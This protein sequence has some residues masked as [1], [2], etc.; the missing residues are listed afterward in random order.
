MDAFPLA[1]EFGLT[2]LYSFGAFVFLLYELI[3]GKLHWS[4]GAYLASVS[5]DCFTFCTCNGLA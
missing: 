5:N 1:T 4:Y 2:L 3:S